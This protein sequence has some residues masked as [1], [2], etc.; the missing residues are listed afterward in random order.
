MGRGLDRQSAKL[1]SSRWAW[2]SPNPS[3]AHESN[4]P[5]P[6]LVPGGGAHSLAREWVGESQFRRG[7]IDCGTPYMY[8]CT[9]WFGPIEGHKWFFQLSSQWESQKNRFAFIFFGKSSFSLP[10]FEISRSCRTASEA[11]AT[12]PPFGPMRDISGFSRFP[13]NFLH[14][15]NPRFHPVVHRLQIHSWILRMCPMFTII[16]T[17]SEF[18]DEIQTKILK[19]V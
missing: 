18:L 11:M 7:D 16:G 12:F 14:L 2:D 10:A 19:G 17:E 4:P 6:P 15:Q 5:P 3:P 1:F 9:L 13:A 8:V